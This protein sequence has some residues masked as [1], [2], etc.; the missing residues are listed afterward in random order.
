MTDEVIKEQ[1]FN[2]EKKDS[3]SDV[4]IKKELIDL[5]TSGRFENIDALVEE[6][7]DESVLKFNYKLNPIITKVNIVCSSV[8]TNT[9]SP[10]TENWLI[11]KPLNSRNIVKGI[12]KT[13]RE[14]KSHGYLLAEYVDKEFNNK[15]RELT[16]YF[17]IG[18]ISKIEISSTTNRTVITREFPV[19]NGDVFR[20][21]KVA[22]GLDFL[23]I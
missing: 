16:L 6:R 8:L 14:I 19:R 10:D 1:C 22:K 2:L 11:G 12:I 9:I 15:T 23:K 13:L 17:T 4:E 3:V 7:A 18:T 20:Y 21:D 5:Y